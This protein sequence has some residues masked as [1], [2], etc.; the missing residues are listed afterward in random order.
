MASP[1]KGSTLYVQKIPVVI[2][3]GEDASK[4][5]D[6]PTA[7]ALGPG[8]CNHG[9]CISRANS[10]RCYRRFADRPWHKPHFELCGFDAREEMRRLADLSTLR[11]R[12]LHERFAGRAGAAVEGLAGRQHRLEGH[13]RKTHALQ[14]LRALRLQC[15]Q[16]RLPCDAVVP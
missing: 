8:I 11:K 10:V 6:T 4:A 13:R 2:G 14:D 9:S 7:A 1:K 5:Q 16:G 15:L 3:Q 12:A